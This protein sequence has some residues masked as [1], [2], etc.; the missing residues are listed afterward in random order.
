M[1]RNRPYPHVEVST[2]VANTPQT[3]TIKG[4]DKGAKRVIYTAFAHDE[5]KHAGLVIQDVKIKIVPRNQ[6][7]IFGGNVEH[8]IYGAPQVLGGARNT[9]LLGFS[10]PAREDLDLTIEAVTPGDVMW[11]IERW[12]VYDEAGPMPAGV[13][14]GGIA[15]V[16]GRSRR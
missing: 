6:S 10:L 9:L 12:L 8:S 7:D 11:R 3:I 14:A 16:P 2:L 5:G 4:P 15:V 13:I 1:Q